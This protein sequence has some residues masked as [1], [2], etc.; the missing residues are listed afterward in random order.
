MKTIEKLE[1]EIEEKENVH[2]EH[3]NFESCPSCVKWFELRATLTQTKEFEKL[4]E[5][6]CGKEIKP[7][8]K[9][10]MPCGD[11]AGGKQLY[12]EW[13]EELLTKIRGKK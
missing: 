9:V 3:C 8:P 7:H 12:C 11:I 2:V 10:K 6:G 5:E 4:I 1:K 13:C